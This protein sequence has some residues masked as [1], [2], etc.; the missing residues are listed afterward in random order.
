MLGLAFAVLNV[1]RLHN[2]QLLLLCIYCNIDDHFTD[3]ALASRGL[4]YLQV[5]RSVCH[6]VEARASFG[7]RSMDCRLDKPVASRSCQVWTPYTLTGLAQVW[8]LLEYATC[9]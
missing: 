7:V 9:V 4:L 6:R 8:S 3:T 1:R 5:F 2:I